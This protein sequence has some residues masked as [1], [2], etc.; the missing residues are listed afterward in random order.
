[1]KVFFDTSVLVAVF[2]GDHP[3]HDVCMGVFRKA[4]RR[5]AF[6]AAHSMAELYAVTTRLPVRPA[7]SCE[8]AL[9]FVESLRARVTPVALSARECAAALEHAA[10]LGVSGGAVCD[11]LLLACARK[12]AADLVYTL[13]ARDF[14]RL[15]QD[16]ARRIRV[17][18]AAG[19][20]SAVTL[21][22]P[23]TRTPGDSNR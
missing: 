2:W 19:T 18:S 9:L 13:D 6:C 14:P 5:S 4:T 22:V 16:L 3:L 1:M 15:A 17:L 11:V 10:R 8:Q 23:S 21:S 12:C 20:R 7:I